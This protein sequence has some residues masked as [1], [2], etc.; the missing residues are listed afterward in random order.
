MN[1]MIFLIEHTKRPKYIAVCEC[2]RVHG[3]YMK[4][5]QIAD[6]CPA[7]EER[8]EAKRRQGAT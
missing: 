1:T 2:G 5:A 7:C 8:T 6:T 3:K 4:V